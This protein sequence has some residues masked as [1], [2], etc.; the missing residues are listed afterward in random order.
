MK[1]DA[2]GSFADAARFP[3]REQ[4]YIR[5]A[6]VAV[7][8]LDYKLSLAQKL[9]AKGVLNASRDD[10]A[11]KIKELTDGSGADVVLDFVGRRA[12]IQKSIDCTAKGG[13]LVVIGISSEELQISPY[14]TIIGK[15]ME[16]LGVNDHLRSE[17]TELIDLVSRGK[18]NL[19]TSITHR[20]KLEEVNQGMQILERNIGAPI[21]VVIEQ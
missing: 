9:G 15:E 1:V 19:S 10:P 16:L 7:D 3:K 17:L 11:Q 18:I 4:R 5:A 21:R 8:L 12:T 20:L 6:R 2:D 14:S 13:R